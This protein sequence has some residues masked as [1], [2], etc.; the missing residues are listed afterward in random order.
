MVVCSLVTKVIVPQPHSS[1][2]GQSS[3][4]RLGQNGRVLKKFFNI[5]LIL[6]ERE[7]RGEQRRGRKRG[8]HRI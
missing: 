7:T 8:R 4:G 6:R 5:Y 2:T 1:R 3:V